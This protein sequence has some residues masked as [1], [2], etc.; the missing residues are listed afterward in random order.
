MKII[1]LKNAEDVGEKAASLVS[2]ELSKDPAMVLGLA[3]GSTVIPLYKNLVSLNKKRK[4]SFSRIK[5]FN[6][7]EY[8]NLKNEKNSFSYFLYKNLLDKVNIKKENIHLLN[9]N[10]DAN[11]ECRAYENKIKSNKIGLQ[12]LGIGRNGHIGFNEPGSNFKS[13]TRKVSLSAATREY[14]SKFFSSIKEVPNYALTLGLST[15]MKSK[16]I[17][18]LATGKNKAEA[19]NELVN[20]PITNKVPASILRKHKSCLL[21]ADR[22]AASRC[23][24]I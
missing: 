16:K 8:C 14:N 13:T 12:L 18:L 9:G 7:D 6:L 24:K 15:I 2:E 19:V 1:I 23:H 10:K 20:G 22:A 3:A 11:Q 4:I 5:V 17:I 21:I